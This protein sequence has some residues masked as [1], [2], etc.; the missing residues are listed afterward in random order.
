MRL[1]LPSIGLSV[2][3]AAAAS[4]S[5]SSSSSVSWCSNPSAYAVLTNCGD[6]CTAGDPC[7]QYSSSSSCNEASRN[8]CIEQSSSCTYQ[9]LSAYNTVARKFTVFVKIPSSSDMWTNTSG[10]S[11]SAFPSAEIDTVSG[12]VFAETTRNIQI[13][14]FDETEVQKGSLKTVAFDE[15]TFST[16][17]TLEELILA[18]LDLNPLPDNFLPNTISLLSMENCNLAFLPSQFGN[19]AQRN[20]KTLNLSKNRL[21]SITGDDKSVAEALQRLDFL[22]LS[23]NMISVFTLD[24][25][26]IITLDLS[27]NQLSDFPLVI[28]NMTNLNVLKIAGN[29]IE[30]LSVTSTQFNFLR[31]LSSESTLSINSGDCSSTSATNVLDSVV[32]VSDFVAS[33]SNESSN[34]SSSS[35]L[36]IIVVVLGVLVVF[37]GAGFFFYRRRLKD[38]ALNGSNTPD[39]VGLASPPPTI[40]NTPPR[41]RAGSRGRALSTQRLPTGGGRTPRVSMPNMLLAEHGKKLSDAQ[42]RRSSGQSTFPVGGMVGRS[43]NSI[44]SANVKQIPS[45]ELNLTRKIA[46]GSFGEVWLALYGRDLVAIKKLLSVE[47]ASVQSF[48]SELNLLASLSHRCILSLLGACWDEELTDIQIIMEYMDSGDLLSVLRSNASSVLTWE[49]GKATYCVEH[50]PRN[51]SP[52]N[53]R[54]SSIR[55]ELATIGGTCASDTYGLA[56]CSKP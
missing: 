7:V 37:G 55:S 32:C 1:L 9:C 42:P 41:N 52:I 36:V 26:S 15:D 27:H 38:H 39:M 13:T 25:P 47:K 18:N 2:G 56:A 53:A 48:V 14:G 34:S 50:V 31:K 45:S 10:V 16:A 51:Y 11:A 54:M 30:T 8:D 21:A 5:S 4:S 20:L 3:S 43:R 23:D 12:V 33:M 24:L 29:T 44:I 49:N 19:F 22:N 17:I 6:V 46:K 40:D 28:F 35:T